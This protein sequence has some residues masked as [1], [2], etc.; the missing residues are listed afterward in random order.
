MVGRRMMVAKAEI[1]KLNIEYPDDRLFKQS[2]HLLELANNWEV[3]SP[4]MA[5][6]AGEDL[7]A[8]KALAKQ[9]DEKRLAITRPINEGLKEVNALFK[10][11][12]KWLAEA[13]TVL[14]AKILAFQREQERIARELQAELDAEAEKERKKLEKKAAKLEAKGKTDKVEEIKE[15]IATAVAPKVESA[16]PKLEGIATRK[17]WKVEVVDKASLILHIA[18]K[19]P[20]LLPLLKVDVSGLNAQARSL[21]GEFALPGIEVAE[22]TSL[23]ARR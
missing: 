18:N 1:V 4:E 19:R 3:L 16:A 11:A 12:K 2:E 23:A 13:E 14:K 6:S 15:E 20:D 22:E 10:P 5:V 21:K 9:V 7:R 17:T 8:V